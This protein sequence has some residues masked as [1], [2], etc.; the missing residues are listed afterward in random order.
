MHNQSIPPGSPGKV[1]IHSELNEADRFS[2]KRRII[3]KIFHKISAPVGDLYSVIQSV[4]SRLATL[5]YCRPY[6]NEY[7]DPKNENTWRDW[8]AGSAGLHV[9]SHGFQGHSSIWNRYIKELR[10]QGGNADIRVPFIPEKGNC[11]LEEATASIRTMVKKYIKKEIDIKQNCAIPT[12]YLYGVSNG[13]RI[14]LNMLNGLVDDEMSKDLENKNLRLNFKIYSI[15]G[16]LRGT[17][18]WQIRL[19]HS[20]RFMNWVARKIFKISPDLLNDFKYESEGSTKLIEMA[21][22]IHKNVDR[23]SFTFDFYASTEDGLM[24][25]YAA[26]LPVLGRGETHNIVHGEGHTSIVNRVLA[27]I[28]QKNFPK[29][30]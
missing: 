3:R 23:I 10:K 25:P 28:M 20:C 4:P 15:A 26:S 12:I 21:R 27:D 11:S 1:Y 29:K 22:L 9:L 14:S 24:K 18:N 30:S 16:V 7:C 17:K 6:R 19:A 8:K 5:F 13:A 2:D